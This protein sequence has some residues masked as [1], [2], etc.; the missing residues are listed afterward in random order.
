MRPVRQ[1]QSPLLVGRDELLVL[2]DRMIDDA[3]AGRGRVLLLAGEAGVG[4]SRLQWAIIRKA[5]AAG[6][7]VA[8]GDLSPHDSQLSLAALFDMAQGMRDDPHLK[9]LGARLL[10]VRGGKGGDSLA[11]RQLLVHEV[12]D[13]FLDSI[14]APT[15]IRV[16]NL[17]WADELTLEVVGELARRAPNLPLLLV[18][19]YRLDELPLAS[20]HREWRSRLLSQRHAEEARLRRLTYEETAL[21]TSLIIGT[22]LPAPREVVAAVY[23]RTDGNPLH[24]EE[25]LAA[26]PDEALSSGRAIREAHVPDTIEDAVLV[27]FARLSPEAQSAARA[28]AVIGRCFIPDVVAG[29]LDRPVTELDQP[30][31]ELVEHGFLHPFQ[32]VDQGYY[33]FHHQLLRDALYGTVPPGELR[34]LHARAAEF[35]SLL[36][37]GGEVHKS[38][39]YERAGLHQQAYQAALAAAEA[40]AAVT[41]RRESF[42]LYRRAAANIPEDLPAGERAALFDEYNDAAFAVDDV[43]V[44]VETARLARRWH[45]E[46]GDPI[47]AARALSFEAGMGRR[48][49]WPM[50]ERRAILDQARAELEALPASLERDQALAEVGEFEVSLVL[51]RDDIPAAERIL[52]EL[53]VL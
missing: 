34:R 49:V 45:L 11:S 7:R 10:A 14:D 24:V 1:V 42:E 37:G 35:G 22:G 5:E 20:F 17:Q 16:D 53:A 28:G 47:A 21:V 29:L 48:D 9:R 40:A 18:G 46:A 38:V 27:R 6:F 32:Y 26:L 41:S 23:E 30:L 12:V 39:H 51:D 52:E 4:K 43:Q 36:V 15:L 19:A 3:A 44:G 13:L 33:D 31:S 2:A 8:M 25:L 50:A